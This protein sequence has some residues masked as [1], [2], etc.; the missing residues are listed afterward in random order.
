MFYMFNNFN[1]SNKSEKHTIKEWEL[2]TG[3]EIVKVFDNTVQKNKLGTQLYTRR[4]F[5]RLV[6]KSTIVCKT[7]KGLEFLSLLN[8]EVWNEQNYNLRR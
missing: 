4:A 5:K 7:E 2:H 6:E 1:P 8:K 3:I